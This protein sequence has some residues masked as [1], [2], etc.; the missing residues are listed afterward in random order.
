M[1]KKQIKRK[2]TRKK[3]TSRS[4]VVKRWMWGLFFAA[5]AG[6]FCAMAAY[7]FIIINGNQYLQENVNKLDLKDAS[8][9][10]DKNGDEAAKFFMLENRESVKLEEVPELVQQAFIATE[11]KR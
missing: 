1:E 6:I 7:L 9:V 11:D 4:K 8:I 3:R 10:F 5:A 2:P